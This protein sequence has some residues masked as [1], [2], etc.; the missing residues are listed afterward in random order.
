MYFAYTLCYCLILKTGHSNK[1]NHYL[2]QGADSPASFPAIYNVFILDNI[3]T[4]ILIQ[5][6]NFDGL[7]DRIFHSV[8][9]NKEKGTAQRGLFTLILKRMFFSPFNL[10]SNV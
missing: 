1:W 9:L 4:L 5:T 8:C 7:I 2:R 6:D 3:Y 10:H